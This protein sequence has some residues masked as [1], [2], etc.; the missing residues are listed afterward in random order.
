MSKQT[1][2]ELNTRIE[3]EKMKNKTDLLKVD[4]NKFWAESVRKYGLSLIPLL[5]YTPLGIRAR[6]EMVEA[7]EN[8]KK[9]ADEILKVRIIV[10]PKDAVIKL[11]EK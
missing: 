9:R 10:P 3:N 4:Y 11:V 5:D 1:V 6:L 8:D 7:T 2:K